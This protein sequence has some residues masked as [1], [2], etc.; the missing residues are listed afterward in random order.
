VLLQQGQIDLQVTTNGQ[1]L[2]RGYHEDAMS[3]D[4]PPPITNLIFVVH[5]IGAKSDRSVS[6][7]FLFNLHKFSFL[8]KNFNTKSNITAF[9][10]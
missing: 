7:D 5:G 1:R 8:N 9:E 2:R 10:S 4:K 6:A 3:D